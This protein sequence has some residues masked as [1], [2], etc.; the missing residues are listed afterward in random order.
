MYVMRYSLS[1]IG[2]IFLLF[3]FFLL[4]TLRDGRPGRR[5]HRRQLLLRLL[6]PQ[7][8]PAELG[9]LPLHARA[10]PGLARPLAQPLLE[11][12]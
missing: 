12:R 11:E 4:L 6:V 3:L 9:L 10:S 7:L 8:G 5:C 1:L 2:L